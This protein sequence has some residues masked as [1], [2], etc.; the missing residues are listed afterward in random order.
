MN[1]NMPVIKII[2]RYIDKGKFVNLYQ[3]KTSLMGKRESFI[4]IIREKKENALE[5]FTKVM[6]KLAIIKFAAVMVAFIAMMVFFFTHL[7]CFTPITLQ[8][9]KWVSSP[10]IGFFIF[11]MVIKFVAVSVGLTATIL[12]VKNTTF[13]EVRLRFKEACKLRLRVFLRRKVQ[14][15][16]IN[17]I[18]L[19]H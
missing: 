1:S 18:L 10:F 6:W 15:Q 14:P 8:F 2:Q 11:I 3:L 9:S 5:T 4:E 13:K 7:N 16:V 12:T 19:R 17:G